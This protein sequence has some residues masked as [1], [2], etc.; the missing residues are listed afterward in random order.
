MSEMVER[1]AQAIYEARNG[2]GTYSGGEVVR[3]TQDAARAA[4]AA[5]REPTEAMRE[6]VNGFGSDDLELYQLLIDAALE[7]PT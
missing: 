2:V 1:V 4:I 5:M 6:A 7:N 3:W